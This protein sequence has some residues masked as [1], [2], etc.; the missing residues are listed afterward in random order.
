MVFHRQKAEEWCTWRFYVYTFDVFSDGL[1]SDAPS[2]HREADDVWSADHHGPAERHT[3][4]T[5]VL[6]ILVYVAGVEVCVMSFLLW[7]DCSMLSVGLCFY[8]AVTQA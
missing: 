6:H 1:Y 5:A 4:K 3:S 7:P 8:G 2:I